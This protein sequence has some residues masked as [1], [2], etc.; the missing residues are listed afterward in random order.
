MT[1]QKTPGKNAI[2][3]I[4]VRIDRLLN[5]E[6]NS[7]KAIASANIGGAFAVHGIK[8]MD[9][10]KGRYIAM[11]GSKYEKNG[12]SLF[13]ES[14]HPVTKEAREALTAA[15]LDAYEQSIGESMDQGMSEES[16]AMSQTM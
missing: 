13:N 6:G 7:V 15:V 2:P 14:F 10:D 11:P 16:A 3:S 12:Q 8:V 9:S 5:Y 4:N 1:T